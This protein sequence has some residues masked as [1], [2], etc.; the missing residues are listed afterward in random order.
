V[1]DQARRRLGGA[2]FRVAGAVAFR[3]ATRF[4]TLPRDAAALRFG[5]VRAA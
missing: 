3:A 1:D 4:T 5:G 2:F